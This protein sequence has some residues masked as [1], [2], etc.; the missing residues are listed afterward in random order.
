MIHFPKDHKRACELSAGTQL[1]AFRFMM[2]ELWVGMYMCYNCFDDKRLDFAP[3]RM[4]QVY[5][6]PSKRKHDAIV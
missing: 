6:W 2:D 3:G 5:S 1:R 4:P